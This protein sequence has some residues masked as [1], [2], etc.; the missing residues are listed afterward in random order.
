VLGGC[1]GVL[2][3]LGTIA[4]STYPHRTFAFVFRL[5][6]VLATAGFITCF[7][8]AAKAFTSHAALLQQ[9]AMALLPFLIV[10]GLLYIPLGGKHPSSNGQAPARPVSGIS[11]LILLYLLFVGISGFM[12]YAGQQAAARGMSVENTILA[13]GAMK[14]AAAM[15]LFFAAYLM[16]SVEGRGTVLEAL[17]LVV[18]IWVVFV[19]RTTVEFFVGFVLL[20]I[21]LN[22]FSARLQASI[23]NAAPRFGGRWLNAVILMG[24]ATGPPLYGLAIGAGQEALS[25]VSISVAICLPLFWQ[26]GWGSPPQAGRNSP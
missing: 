14:I 24:S 12:G 23:V 9:L 15:W 10:G 26:I 4:A 20:E 25:V 7:L 21:T 11:G 2:K 22:G 13:I 5:A 19:S 8:L 6:L 17:L 1:C 18:A 16:P 3:F